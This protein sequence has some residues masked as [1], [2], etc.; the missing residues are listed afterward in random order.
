MKQRTTPERPYARFTLLMENEYASAVSGR[1]IPL[2][3][4]HVYRPE[5]SATLGFMINVPCFMVARFS[6]H[7]RL[8]SSIPLC[9]QRWVTFD[10]KAFASHTNSTRS[11]S[12]LVRL[13]GGNVITAGPAMMI[14]VVVLIEPSRLRL[15][16]RY[17]P[18]SFNCMLPI[19]SSFDVMCTLALL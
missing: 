7:N 19:R 10:G 16:Q 11:P 15:V 9:N 8:D 1:P 12:N 18:I 14:L 4:S 6:I 13:R 2:D 5:S 17:S 3:T